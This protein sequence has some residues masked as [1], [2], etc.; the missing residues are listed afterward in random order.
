MISFKYLLANNSEFK[1][2]ADVLQNVISDAYFQKAK[3]LTRDVQDRRDERERRRVKESWEI[4]RCTSWALIY[5]LAHNGKLDYILN[6]GK[7]LDKLPRD[8]DL[9]STVMQGSFAKA[10]D[11]VDPNNL[12]LIDDLKLK[13][14][15]DAWFAMMD[16]ANLD[17]A[18]LQKFLQDE[19][20]K[21]DPTASPIIPV[22]VNP[23]PNPSPPS[24]VPAGWV[25]YTSNAG[26]YRTVF[27]QQPKESTQDAG[28]LKVKVYLAAVEMKAQGRTYFVM[29]NDMPAA[30]DPSLTDKALDGGVGAL[31]KLGTVTTSSKISLGSNSGREAVIDLPGGEKYKVRMYMVGSRLYQIHAQWD[32][33]K[34]DASADVDAFMNAFKLVDGGAAPAGPPNP[35]PPPPP[36]A[37]NGDLTGTSWGGKETLPSYGPLSF[38]FQA[39]GQVTMTDKDGNSQGKYQKQGNNITIQFDGSTYNGT[40]NGNAMQGTATNGMN[41]WNWNVTSGAQA[42]QGLNPANPMTPPKKGPTKGG[43]G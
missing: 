7:E 39:N 16:G 40:I 11:M 17:N 18:S 4:A 2:P 38:Q 14:R 10:F 9:S 42:I 23:S 12:Q 36:P 27:P 43:R 20:A 8:L 15:A 31:G 35:A 37:G 6:Y 29:Y 3:E 32:P 13:G 30:L 34:G 1:S 22:A 33:K 24:G 41:N 21:D 5:Y 28:G 19:R 25:E 26:R